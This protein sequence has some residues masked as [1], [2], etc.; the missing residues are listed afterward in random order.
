[1][2]RSQWLLVV[3]TRL[4]VGGV[5]QVWLVQLSSYRLFAYVGPR[6]FEA[7]HWA[8]WRSIWGPV[9][10]P[11]ALVF[12]GA[13]VMLWMRPPG[14]PSWALWLGFALEL[15]LGVGTAI[16]ASVTTVLPHDGAI[17][18]EPGSDLRRLPRPTVGELG[19]LRDAV[20]LRFHC[21]RVFP[22][23]V[24]G[25]APRRGA[26]CL[27]RLLRIRSIATTA[28]VGFPAAFSLVCNGANGLFFPPGT[29]GSIEATVFYI[30]TA[31]TVTLVS[32]V[33]VPNGGGSTVP[34]P[35]SI[36]LLGTGLTGL[37]AVRCRH[38]IDDDAA[39]R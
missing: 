37:I 36:M 21:G 14:I 15:L 5:G 6:E 1:M 12:V 22:E 4:A 7:Y 8:W 17:E 28:C 2:I 10:S 32:S 27:G 39:R 18:R 11:A 3:M 34:E 19:P 33:E 29:S 13:I 23:Q 38:A 24:S 9:I 30:T 16:W 20:A 35:A 25:V 26:A 31:A